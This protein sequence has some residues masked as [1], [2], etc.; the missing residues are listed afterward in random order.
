M[1][2]EMNSNVF[3]TLALQPALQICTSLSTSTQMAAYLLLRTDSQTRVGLSVGAQGVANLCAAFPGAWLGDRYGRK[4]VIRTAVFIGCVGFAALCLAINSGLGPS[5]EF[6]AIS[7]ALFTIGMY[8]GTQNSS[9]EA[10]F[11]DSVASGARS[12]LYARKASLRILGNATGPLVAVC[13]FAYLGNNWKATELR[14]CISIGAVLFVFPCICALSLSEKKTLGAASEA[15]IPGQ[16]IAADEDETKK[17]TL[18]ASGP[19]SSSM[20]SL[21]DDDDDAPQS[22]EAIRMRTRIATTV[23]VSDL[24]ITL[25]A[26]FSI[27]F[28]PLFLIERGH[29]SPI[30][31]NA[32]QG[33]GPLGAAAAA[34]LAQKA[35]RRFGRVQITYIT[36]VMGVLC[37]VGMAAAKRTYL[38]VALYVFRICMV[39]CGTGLTKSILNDYVTK[40]ERARW[41]SAEAINVFGWSGSA[42]LGGYIIERHGYEAMFLVTAAIQLVAA[43]F[44]LT[45]VHLVHAEVPSSKKKSKLA[46]LAAP[47]LDDTNASPRHPSTASEAGYSLLE[48]GAEAEEEQSDLDIPID[49]DFEDHG[50]A[51]PSP[52]SS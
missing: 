17:E 27:K 34:L 31:V 20:S 23:V 42:S 2:K 41:N 44:L 13:A 5:A 3:Y 8:Q 33:C 29:L 1:S 36:K 10:I 11:G 16:R 50:D 30:E 46:D 52:S 47:L 14:W 26:G 12:K 19:S 39:N 38:I 25:G 7:A 22:K 9:V 48:F 40:K 28:V 45:I 51:D 21:E 4:V 37:L 15:L 32:I 24:M 18:P 43:S 49:D 35:S 6:L